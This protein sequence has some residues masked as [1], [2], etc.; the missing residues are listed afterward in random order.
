LLLVTL[1]QSIHLSK[2]RAQIQ[3]LTQTVALLPYTINE[4]LR[5][6][7]LDTT[8]IPGD[9]AVFSHPIA[10]TATSQDGYR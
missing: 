7:S 6:T 10:K 5:E 4:N 9:D 3:Q 8:N 2:L 1:Y